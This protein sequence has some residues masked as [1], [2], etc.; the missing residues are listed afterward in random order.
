[1]EEVIRDRVFFEE[2]GGGVTFSG[3]EPLAQPRFLLECLDACRRHGL[4]VAVDTCGHAA[5]EVVLET[6]R[7]A[8]LVLFDVKVLDS[9]RHRGLTGVDNR[10]IL[11]NLEM[12]AR[13]DT[14]LWLRVPVL[15][16]LN[17]DDANLEATARLAVS[18]GS[19]RRVCLLP[20]HRAG[21]AKQ[22]AER[23]A[24]PGGN[25]HPP[26]PDRLREIARRF[27]AYG[28]AVSVGG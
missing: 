24:G 23:V 15:P 17:D 27:E 26:E 1:V 28:L 10:L 16:G 2:S 9:A 4:H 3:G 11:A 19:V 25:L 8:D 12:L 5:P 21:T 14:P 22:S 7:R 18:L 6:A 13:R 20:Y